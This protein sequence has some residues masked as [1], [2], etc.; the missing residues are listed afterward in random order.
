MLWRQAW[1]GGTN[2]LGLGVRKGARGPITWYMFVFLGNTIICTL[3][4]L[5]LSDQT[6]VSLQLGL[7]EFM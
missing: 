5:T 4:K 3:Y 1:S 7:S 6:Q 2:Y